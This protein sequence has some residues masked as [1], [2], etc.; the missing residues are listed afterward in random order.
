MI[1]YLILNTLFH[2]VGVLFILFPYF[3]IKVWGGTSLVVQW[4][5]LYTSTSGG[6]GSIP[7]QG[8]SACSKKKKKKSLQ[9][10]KNIK[11]KFKVTGFREH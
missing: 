5:R 1:P 4:L 2:S 9:I 6:M 11:K 3:K 8:S 7:G 10:I